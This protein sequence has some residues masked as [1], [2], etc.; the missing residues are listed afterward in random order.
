MGALALVLLSAAG[1]AFLAL[2]FVQFR[3]EWKKDRAARQAVQC[4]R[5]NAER[6]PKAKVIEITDW[7]EDALQDDERRIA[8]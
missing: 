6:G 4:I 1:E 8:S 5:L 2:C 3:R 7:N